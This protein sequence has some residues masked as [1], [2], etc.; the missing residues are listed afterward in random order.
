[1]NSKNYIVIATLAL[2]GLFMQS[3]GGESTAKETAKAEVK[4]RVEIAKLAN[5]PELMSFSGKLE[6]ETHSNLSTRVMGQI[7][8]I[9]VETGQ[10]V[11]KGQ[12]LV[13]IHAKDIQAKKAQVKAN[14]LE[15]EA[16]YN[17]AKKDYDRFTVLFEQKSASQK[18][19]D[20]VSTQYN[21]AKARL[22]AVI[23]MG[24]EVEEM[25]R[26]TT[27]KAPYNGVITKKYKNEGDLASPGI[28]LVAIEKPNQFKVMARIPETEISKIKKNDPVLVEIKALGDVKVN[29]VVAEVNP[30]AQYTGNQ[31]EA[32]IVLQPDADQKAKMFS[33]MFANVIIEKGGMPSILV[34]KNVLVNKGQLIG[35]YTVSQS[36]TAM[37][38]W[39]RTGK[40]NGDMIEVLSGLRDGEKF[41]LS[42]SGKI[43]DGAKVEIQ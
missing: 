17:N 10:K 7:E 31:F 36:G 29:G 33:G 4:V 13:Q 21:M 5:Q 16:A 37:L 30:S 1:M 40:I 6:A 8:K 9:N 12:V 11:S 14:K 34:P 26:Y 28:P 23:E 15:A 32:K 41:I 38:R 20:D 19:M 18:E 3:C 2:S 22:E 42:H 24:V 39:I 35:I 27:I 43:W 25:L